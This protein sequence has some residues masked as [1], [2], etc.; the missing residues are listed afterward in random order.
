MN[1][2]KLLMITMVVV[3]L[4]IFLFAIAGCNPPAMRTITLKH[5]AVGIEL[6]C[7]DYTVGVLNYGD[8][9]REITMK[10]IC[11]NLG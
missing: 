4:F 11:D 2:N 7:D 8:Y 5:P 10:E 6:N 1:E 3:S 9:Q